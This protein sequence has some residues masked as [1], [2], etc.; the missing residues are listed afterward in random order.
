M[1]KQVGDHPCIRAFGDLHRR[2]GVTEVVQTDAIETSRV[3]CCSKRLAERVRFD[4][5]PIAAVEDE[6]LIIPSG[7]DRPATLIRGISAKLV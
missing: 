7:T 3:P 5:P 1:T 2:G 6:S 4:G